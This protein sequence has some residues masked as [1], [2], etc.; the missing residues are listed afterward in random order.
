MT[1]STG[2]DVPRGPSRG[3]FLDEVKDA[4]TPRATLLVVG[5]VAL[6]L[7]F[8]A[9]YVGALHDPRPKDVPF[10]VVAPQA[11]ARQTVARLEK[12]P[13]DPLDPRAV[14]DAA[15][16]RAQILDRKID[17]ALVVGPTGGADTLLVATGGGKVLAA[18][19]VT[20]TTALEKS[21]ARTLRTVDVVPADKEDANGLS[22]FYLTVGWCV[23]GYLCAS[24]MVISSGAGRSTPRRAV[25][26]LLA[27]A[28]VGIVGGLGGALIVGP[29]LD[30]LPGSLAAYWGL[31]ALIVFAVGAATL[32]FQGVFG[33]A[34][35]GLVILLVVIL[36]N[37]S[38]GGAL[39]PPLLPPFWKAIGP[40]LPPGAGTWAARSIAYFEGN[41]MTASLLVLSAWA[42][43]GVVVTLLASALRTRRAQSTP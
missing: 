42:V 8:I 34:G 1:Q 24:I 18:T 39:P 40:A 29:V 12:L 11:V 3:S 16:A 25:I 5:V 27:M 13:G 26:R 31:G 33:L 37:P 9:S 10:G 19:L 2:A 6:H 17:G 38:A 23:G 7:L 22:S 43:A 36:G 21:Q 15:T 30:A 14:A 20:L 28:V 41:D 35:I 32:A 4:V